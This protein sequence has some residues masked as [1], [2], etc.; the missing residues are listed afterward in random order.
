MFPIGDQDVRGGRPPIVTVLLIALN[1]L[2]FVYQLTLGQE[3]LVAFVEEWGAVPAAL[4]EGDR[5]IT[6]ITCMFIHGGW[7]HIIGNML[8]LW[9]FGDNVEAV[10]GHL[11]YLIFY[12]LG[13][14]AATFAQVLSDPTST[15]PSVGASGAIA[16]VLGAYLLM[17]PRARVRLLIFLGIFIT[18]T[19]VSALAFIGIW[20]VMQLF[21]GVAALG[22]PTAQ[23]SG[24]AYW[25][26]IGGFAFGLLA[27]LLFRGRAA[28]VALERERYY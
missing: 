19:R 15:I 20:A 11:G 7:L 27:G 8:F 13:G 1:A 26:H 28:G 17:F 3:R 18:T 16:A 25:A 10:L 6:L 5:L 9:V 12:L 21:S 22:A 14:I 2:V 4:L 24:V 23:T